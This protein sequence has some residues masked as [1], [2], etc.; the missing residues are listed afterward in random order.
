MENLSFEDHNKFLAL[1]PTYHSHREEINRNP[2]WPDLWM[3]PDESIIFERECIQIPSYISDVKP[4]VELTAVIGEEIWQASEQDAW[5]SIKGFTISNDVTATSEW[6]G[7]PESGKMKTNFGYKMFP[8]FS[9]VLSKY[10]HKKEI[11]DCSELEMNVKVDGEDSIIGNTEEMH[12]SVP[13][14]VSY[15][16]YIC[17]LNKGDLIALGDPGYPDVFLDNANNVSC[18]IESIGTL[19]NGIERVQSADPP[20][21]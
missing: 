19:S 20:L 5:E 17:K 21:R 2:K 14:M 1:G 13:E 15:V 12:F 16:S 8:T 4:G 10:K 18:Y 11:T 6:P 9:P 3:V 7:W